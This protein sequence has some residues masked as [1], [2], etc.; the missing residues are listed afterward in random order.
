MGDI[1]FKKVGKYEFSLD[2]PIDSDLMLATLCR[3]YV[4]TVSTFAWW[5]AWL[6]KTLD[7]VVITYKNWCSCEFEFQPDLLPERWIKI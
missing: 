4:L 6:S 3:S 1:K 2:V 7:P 5:G